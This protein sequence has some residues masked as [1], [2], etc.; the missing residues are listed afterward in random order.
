MSTLAKEFETTSQLPPSTPQQRVTPPTVLLPATLAILPP[1][2]AALSAALAATTTAAAAGVATTPNGGGTNVPTLQMPALGLGVSS[3]PAPASVAQVTSSPTSTLPMLFGSTPMYTTVDLSSSTVLHK[4]PESET[5]SSGIY[6]ANVTA[7][8]AAAAAGEASRQ[9]PTLDREACL[10]MTGSSGHLSLLLSMPNACPPQSTPPPCRGSASSSPAAAPV[11]SVTGPVSSLPHHHLISG[12]RTSTAEVDFFMPL[13]PASSTYATRRSVSASDNSAVMAF[14]CAGVQSRTHSCSSG[15]CSTSRPPQQR[16]RPTSATATTSIRL[17]SPTGL[18]HAAQN[19]L[20]WQQHDGTNTVATAAR[21]TSAHSSVPSASSTPPATGCHV[22]VGQPLAVYPS[23]GVDGGVCAFCPI[24]SVVETTSHKKNSAERLLT[25]SVSQQQQQQQ[26]HGS[27]SLQLPNRPRMSAG[28]GAP[29]SSVGR[30]A[31][32][33]RRHYTRTHVSLH[34][35]PIVVATTPV[36]PSVGR[37]TPSSPLYVSPGLS[38]YA[39]PVR[40]LTTSPYSTSPPLTSPAL[41]GQARR[42]NAWGDLSSFL[43]TTSRPPTPPSGGAPAGGSGG[44]YPCRP[45]S[46]IHPSANISNVSSGS[47]NATDPLSDFPARPH[48]HP[49][50]SSQQRQHLYAHSIFSSAT[51]ATTATNAASG[52]FPGH[53]TF[54]PIEVQPTATVTPFFG[55]MGSVGVAVAATSPS[56]STTRTCASRTHAQEYGVAH[57]HDAAHRVVPAM[58]RLERPASSSDEPSCSGCVSA[59]AATPT[60]PHVAWTSH[61]GPGVVTAILA[62]PEV[63]WSSF[64]AAAAD[65]AAATSAATGSSY[66]GSASGSA[67]THSPC[68]SCSFTQATSPAPWLQRMSSGAGGSSSDPVTAGCCPP[69]A[70][71]HFPSNHNNISDTVTH[72][73]SS[74]YPIGSANAEGGTP[75][76]TPL[77]HTVSASVHSY[78]AALPTFSATGQFQLSCSAVPLEDTESQCVICFEGHP[79]QVDSEAPANPG[80]AQ[81]RHIAADGPTTDFGGGVKPGS[82]LLMMPCKHCCHQNC[83]QRWLIQSTHCPICRRDLAQDATLSS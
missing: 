14:D 28:E 58:P 22:P 30:H 77:T 80:N 71:N 82:Q 26:Q 36:S 9:P 46:G 48:S 19:G 75:N 41:D 66:E 18:T 83:L 10:R 70:T 3:A 76:R 57:D 47:L 29:A 31:A 49:P 8:A 62:A 35:G 12:S 15:S 67:D 74:R 65:S 23:W 81:G 60:H 44:V 40:Q 61:A 45:A 1:Q 2:S 38:F 64:N 20:P 78:S 13:T 7:A 25:S 43:S 56:V 68:N 79:C 63:S 39:D 50:P 11:P 33:P 54:L 6:A 59:S 27:R 17:H 73:G 52:A 51:T 69:H 24:T 42:E 32:A 72:S 5:A 34:E 37:R 53:L 55:S 4:S 21:G 16:H